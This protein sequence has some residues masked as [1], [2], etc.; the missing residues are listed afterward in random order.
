MADK[1]KVGQISR[2]VLLEADAGLL[3]ECEDISLD[4]L[5][6]LVTAVINSVNSHAYMPKV[7]ADK[8]I[9]LL[10]AIVKEQGKGN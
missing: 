1:I 3:E 7:K 5:L 8:A 9:Y 4:Y 6:S 2:L 10:A